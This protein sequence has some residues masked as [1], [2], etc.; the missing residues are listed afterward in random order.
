MCIRDRARFYEELA[1][2]VPLRIPGCYFAA[3][4]EERT[5]YVMVLE[6]LEASG[7]T[8]TNLVE[9]GTAEHGAKL[10]Q[11]LARLHARFWE[12]PRFDDELAWVTPAMRGKRG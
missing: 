4:G 11:A 5:Q 10:V 9:T 6:D 8:F 12:N 3:H 2:E 1:P 7:C